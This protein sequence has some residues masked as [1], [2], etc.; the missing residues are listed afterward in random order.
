M[1]STLPVQTG[2]GPRVTGLI[3]AGG[4]GSRMGGQDKGLLA[5]RGE[6]LVCQVAHRLAPQVDRLMVSANRS[7][8]DYRRLGFEVTTDADPEA[9]H[10]PLAG[11]L[12]GLLASESEWLAVAPC[13]AP[14]LPTDLV[15]R[16][17][18]AAREGHAEAAYVCVPQEGGE[19]QAHPAHCLV[20][21]L[22]AA[23]L[24]GALRS[25]QRRLM[26]WLDGVP[27]LRVAFDEP[28]AFANVNTPEAL[29]AL[30]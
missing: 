30:E 18:R 10:G 23:S 3:L 7:L 4:R 21:R 17:V 12:A 9:F 14:M 6:P 26:D 20:S 5:F 22:L 29:R 28:S 27:A 1:P 25:G 2:S 24:E 19:P 8:A 11:L 16:L 13:D 15:A